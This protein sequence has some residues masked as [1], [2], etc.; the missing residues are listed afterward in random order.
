MKKILLSTIAVL[1]AVAAQAQSAS[2]AG[3]ASAEVDYK[4]VKGLH[5]SVGEEIRSNDNFSALGSLRTNVTLS[6]K[7]A[8]FLKLGAGY[9][10][11]NP[12]KN[13]KT[14]ALPNTTVSGHPSTGFMPALPAS[15]AWVISIS[16]C[17][18]GCSSPITG[19]PA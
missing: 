15:C 11:I 17:A 13:G 14:K 12:W 5:L 16:P 2:F 18:N 6:Y 19:I 9:T 10:L 7:P 1:V 8:Q 3:R 4:I